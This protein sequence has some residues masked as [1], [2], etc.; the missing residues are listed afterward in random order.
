MIAETTLE[1]SIRKANAKNVRDYKI[2]KKMGKI[3]S[4]TQIFLNAMCSY[5]SSFD[6]VTCS[7]HCY[8][9]SLNDAYYSSFI[10]VFSFQFY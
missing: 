8:I 10:I 4:S 9:F 3:S 5:M 1:M 2:M 6:H 7:F